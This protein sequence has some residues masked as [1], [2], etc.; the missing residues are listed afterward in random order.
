MNQMQEM[1]EFLA[2]LAD[3]DMQLSTEKKLAMELRALDAR[4]EGALRIALRKLPLEGENALHDLYE[5]LAHDP[6]RWGDLL[7]DELD[8]L[9]AAAVRSQNPAQVLKPVYAFSSLVA[10]ADGPLQRK[11]RECLAPYLDSHVEI[12]RQRAAWLIGDFTFG[13]NRK[14]IDK[15]RAMVEHDESWRVRYAA[16]LALN[17]AGSVQPGMKLPLLDRLRARFLKPAF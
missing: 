12:V 10:D 15:L 16:F 17:E 13:E 6:G 8:R 9:F 5:L 3:A 11:L 14:I 7:V 4:Q 2:R 1:E